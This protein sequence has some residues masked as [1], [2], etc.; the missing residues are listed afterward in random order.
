VVGAS[1]LGGEEYG[2]EGAEEHGE[3]RAQWVAFGGC[4]GK[5]R[6]SF[7]HRP[8]ARRGDAEGGGCMRR[9]WSGR[10]GWSA[11]PTRGGGSGHAAIVPARR[12]RP[13]AV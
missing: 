1:A 2:D 6:D 8:I 4:H 9:A 5:R 13:G 3:S 7:S 11:A 10:G 12:Q